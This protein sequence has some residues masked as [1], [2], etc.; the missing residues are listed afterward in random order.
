MV[1]LYLHGW[2]SVPGG[3]KPSHLRQQGAQVIE[4]ALPADEFEASIAIA[5]AARRDQPPHLIVGSS[6]GGAV[7]MN[8]DSGDLP[9]ILLA[10]AWKRWGSVDQVKPGTRILH[11]EAD[12]V[13]A[14]EDSQELSARSG[15]AASALIRTGE[16]HRLA[17]PASL[18]RLW[19]TVLATFHGV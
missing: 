11:S 13:I 2:Q 10:P 14:F 5:E 4:P 7:A 16:E 8:M 9:L 15:L 18:D 17:D 3:V 6:R 1:I 19:Q 12:E